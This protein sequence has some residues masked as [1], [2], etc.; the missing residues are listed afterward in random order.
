MECGKV[1]GVRRVLVFIGCEACL[2]FKGRFALLPR[3][4]K[5][6]GFQ[7]TLRPSCEMT[8]LTFSHNH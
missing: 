7:T 8:T 2:S 4:V 5:Y 1:E 3:S 6:R